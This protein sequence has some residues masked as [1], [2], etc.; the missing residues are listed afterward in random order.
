MKFELISEKEKA[1]RPPKR[2][3]EMVDFPRMPG[4]TVCYQQP[5]YKQALVNL[6][7]A[8]CDSTALQK[9]RNRFYRIE[10]NN[11]YIVEI[12]PAVEYYKIALRMIRDNLHTIMIARNEIEK[13]IG[14]IQQLF[15]ERKERLPG[16]QYRIA[17]DREIYKIRTDFLRSYCL[18]ERCW[19]HFPPFSKRYTHHG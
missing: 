18:C 13:S 9:P 10:S 8:I 11:G 1:N 16:G 19:I 3:N 14:A 4:K 17:F 2:R 5:L 7:S 15:R 6:Q 12:Y